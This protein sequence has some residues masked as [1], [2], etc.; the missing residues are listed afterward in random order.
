MAGRHR[1]VPSTVPVRGQ[2]AKE[3][4]KTVGRRRKLEKPNTWFGFLHASVAEDLEVR[5]DP[6]ELTE[7]EILAWADAYR[8]RTGQ[9][10]S[11][12]SGPVAQ[13]PG[14]TWLAVEAALALGLRGLPGR[15][16]IPRLL[17]EHRG[18][19]NPRGSRFT[20]TQI[21]AWADAYH[22]RMGQW[23][24]ADSG[25]I[26][27]REGLTWSILDNALRRGQGGLRSGSSLSRL[28]AGERGVFHDVGQLRLT[29]QTIVAWADAWHSRTGQWPIQTSGDIPG[30]EGIS[31]ASVDD[32]LR[33]GRSALRAGSSLSR[34]LAAQRGVVRRL[35]EPLTEAQILAWADEH[36]ERTGC[37]PSCDRVS[38]AGAAPGETWEKVYNA[39]NRGSRGLPAGSSLPRLLAEHRGVRNK[40]DLPHL[41]AKR[42]LAWADAHHSRTGGWPNPGSGPI[43]EAPGETWSAVD[44]ALNEGI[45]GLGGGSS[46]IQLLVKRRGIRNR[47]HPPPLS[48]RRILAWADAFHARTGRWPTSSSGPIAEAPGETWHA[49]YIA[50]RTGL[51][52]LPGG[53][54]M[55]RLLAQKRGVRNEKDRPPLTI[56][57]ILRWADAHH[58]RHGTWPKSQSGPIPEATGETWLRVH[59]SLVQGNRGLPGGSSLPRLLAR[60]RGVRNLGDLVPFT[61]ERIL[62]WADAHHARTGQWPTCRSGPIAEAPAENWQG[63][64]SALYMGLRGLPGG[65]SLARLLAQKRGVHNAASGRNGS[66]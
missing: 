12:R 58:E 28:L 38:I 3:T 45:R 2:T 5:G 66:G 49:I 18:R 63:V 24:I 10:P 65:S 19:Y 42:I 7:D 52:G 41:S 34:L 26:P 54:S 47:N 43:P 4:G 20:I 9:W 15:S 25:D 48:I 55:G 27:D 21:L 30:L 22:S 36:Y 33:H 50:L 17:D 23:P 31:W 44:T 8:A 39:L 37:W 51:R 29:E 14:E 60:K 46:L 56:P 40:G 16:T 61:V 35:D 64:E 62:A 57:G 32:A 6:P 1:A 11:W 59:Y 13:A 53:S